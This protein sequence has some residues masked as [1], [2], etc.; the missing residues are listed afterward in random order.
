MN[1]TGKQRSY[2]RGEANDL[3]PIT[4]IGKD[5]LSDSLVSQIEECLEDHEL[6]KI[7][8][9]DNNT[10]TAKEAA[11]ELAERTNSHIVQIIGSVLILYKANPEID[12]FNLP[13]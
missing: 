1:L 2:L 8:I 6:I 12:G 4:Q 11:T 3:A 5:G 7:R 9:N 13:S 10:I